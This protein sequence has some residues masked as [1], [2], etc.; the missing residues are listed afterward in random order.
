MRDEGR[1]KGENKR[2]REKGRIGVRAEGGTI[3]NG[4]Y[5]F[6]SFN[7]HDYCKYIEIFF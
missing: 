5:I 6:F 2:G 3:I 4:I 7:N 1:K